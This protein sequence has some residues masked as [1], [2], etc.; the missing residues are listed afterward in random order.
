MHYSYFCRLFERNFSSFLIYFISIKL[1]KIIHYSASCF[2]R[3]EYPDQMLKF[4]R[5]FSHEAPKF[6]AQNPD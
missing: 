2:L 6:H 1:V 4:E 5:N 3:I